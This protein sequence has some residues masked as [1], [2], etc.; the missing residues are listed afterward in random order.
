VSA[1]R[2]VTGV[3]N[4]GTA[5]GGTLRGDLAMG[6][7]NVVHCTDTVENAPGEVRRFFSEDEIFDYSKTEWLHVYLDEER[8]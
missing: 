3:T 7:S 4:A 5:D 1:V 8:L 6:M 2:L